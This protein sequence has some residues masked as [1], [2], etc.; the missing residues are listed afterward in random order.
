MPTSNI[1]FDA[2]LESEYDKLSGGCPSS[3]NVIVDAAGSIMRRPGYG[4]HATF[5][6]TVIDSTGIIGLH[7]SYEDVMFV[8]SNQGYVYHVTNSATN[9]GSISGSGRTSF[10]ETEALVAATRG[11]RAYRWDKSAI[12][13]GVLT[14][15]PLC[16]HLVSYDTRLWANDLTIK[17]HVQYT[18]VNIG[19]SSYSGHEDWTRVF[20]PTAR[21]DPVVGLVEAG[22][23]LYVFG[24]SYTEIRR[25][26]GGLSPALVGGFDHG[27]ASEHLA[28]SHNGIVY[29]MDHHKR[30]W[31]ASGG[32]LSEIS[33][34]IDMV[35]FT[36]LTGS[37]AYA[38]HAGFM[39]G[40]VFAIP[41]HGVHL[42]YNANS[43]KWSY[44]HG[45]DMGLF[46]VSAVAERRGADEQ[47]V[48]TSSGAVFQMSDSFLTDNGDPITAYVDTG[49]QNNGT[50]NQ[51]L[52]KS[53]KL[54][55]ERGS[56]DDAGAVRIQWRDTLG[57]W[58]SPLE[59]SLGGYGDSNP[60]VTFY[61]LGCYRRRQWRISFE[62]SAK[63][64][65][66]AAFEDFE[67]LGV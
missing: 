48:A 49:F 35:P 55:L 36:D 4:P 6:S 51:K 32:E 62:G 10:A 9:V 60:V 17:S 33:Q 19:S 23:E 53:I 56:Q 43:G 37:F 34:S 22:S 16:S 59:A 57:E 39:D 31:S 66:V 14:N 65:L 27:L 41:A 64:L 47:F 40:V 20:T 52:C 46:P 15:A 3:I 45:P 38:V 50:E 1:R 42:A 30:L 58:S 21:P 5:P 29:W 8:A 12:S 61:G 2:G 25:M 28:T 7:L 18:D 67:V 26:V 63:L 24:Q 44:W 13:W 11:A 54:V